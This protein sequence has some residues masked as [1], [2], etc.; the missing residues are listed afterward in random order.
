MMPYPFYG[1]T[2]VFT[3]PDGSR[4]SVRGWGNQFH[5]VFE[6]LDG[7]TL[8]KDPVTGFFQYAKSSADKKR[9]EPA[10]G[11]AAVKPEAMHLAKH[12]RVSK[13]TARQMAGAMFSRTLSKNRW[14][15]RRDKAKLAQRK[16][17]GKPGIVPAPPR[18]ERKG[19][20]TG[21]C[22]LIGFPDVPGVIPQSDVENFCNQEGYSGFG[23]NGSVYDYFFDVSRGKLRYKNIVTGYYTAKKNKGYY[24]DRTVECPVRTLELIEEALAD[25]RAKGFDF[26]RLSVD[27]E[28]YVYAVN[29][30]Y[31]GTCDN[32]WGE[33]MWPHSWHL[34]TPFDVGN[35][36]K[37]MDYQ[38]TDMGSELAIA[39]F[40]HENG[41]MVCDFPDLYDYGDQ[42]CGVGNFCLMC[43]GGPDARNP[44]G[45][46]AYLKY[47]AG[48]A[49]S[50]TPVTGGEFQARADAND[51]FIWQKNPF[52]YFI[53]ENRLAEGRDAGLPSSGLAIWHVD[54]EGDNENE[55]M[56]PDKHYEC[57]LEQA[58]N[59]F[60]MENRRNAGDRDD[61]Y[62]PPLHTG[63]GDET[64]P[65]SRWWDGTPSGLEITGIGNPGKEIR[66]TVKKKE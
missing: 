44:T 66:F 53:F 49:D 29:A 12:L 56:A 47:K 17:F 26:S 57:S 36:R 14:E 19:D 2:F 61:L 42:S 30:F 10:G 28:G 46:C 13:D 39:T 11:I 31:A 23:N 65:G 60:D 33:G 15:Q 50:V 16:A 18:E 1:K 63:F 55:D 4:I 6:T 25:L 37:C 8:V 48:W 7:F 51:L 43:Y 38:I 35:G 27:P 41:H 45:V 5:A 54:E 20:Y 32:E 22:L 40:C 62:F 64:E 34:E 9:L 3:Q 52:E 21:L 58:D 59:R 24:T